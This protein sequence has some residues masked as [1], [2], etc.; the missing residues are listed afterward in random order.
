VATSKQPSDTAPSDPLDG[1]EIE[2]VVTN[3]MG[4]GEEYMWNR[5]THRFTRLEYGEMLIEP[6][7]DVVGR[8]PS[9]LIAPG[10]WRASL[11]RKA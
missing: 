8:I 10:A 11:A 1:Y 2:E 3:I 9:H 7:P 5:S 4:R 6:R